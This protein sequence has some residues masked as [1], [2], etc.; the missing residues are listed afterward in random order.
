MTIRDNR[1]LRIAYETLLFI[2]EKLADHTI[3]EESRERANQRMIERKREIRAYL[4]KPE[5][6]RIIVQ[7][8]FDSCTYRFPLPDYIRSIEDGEEYFREVEYMR[9][10][11]SMYDCTGQLF[12]TWFKVYQA[13][14][15]SFW[16]YHSVGMDV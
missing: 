10:R 8:D 13:S 14:D 4:R 2:E 1:D 15:G 6:V 12:T 5:P 16:A 9:Y 11:P 3:P 7:S